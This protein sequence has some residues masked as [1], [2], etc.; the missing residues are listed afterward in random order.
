MIDK[1][2]NK[3]DLEDIKD[4]TGNKEYTLLTYT[5]ISLVNGDRHWGVIY[6]REFT[7]CYVVVDLEDGVVIGVFKEAAIAGFL[8]RY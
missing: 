1:H 5:G 3:K 6:Y 8:F 7:K 2:T 4:S